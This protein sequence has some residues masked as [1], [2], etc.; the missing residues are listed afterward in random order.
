M[1]TRAAVLLVLMASA[2]YTHSAGKETPNR[3]DG[4]WTNDAGVTLTAK[5]GRLTWTIA[6]ITLTADYS[7]TKDS[8]AYGIVTKIG[9]TNTTTRYPQ[10]PSWTTSCPRWTT[11]SASASG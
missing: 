2:G 5:D 1:I 10:H 8:M 11:P 3:P 7:V 9:Y 4:H 6:G